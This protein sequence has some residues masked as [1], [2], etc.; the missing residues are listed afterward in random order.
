MQSTQRKWQSM[1]F[2]LCSA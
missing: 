1:V 2:S